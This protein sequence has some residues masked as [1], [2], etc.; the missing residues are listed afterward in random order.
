MKNDNFQIY[1]CNGEPIGRPEGYKNHSTALAIV[2]RYNGK[3]R[4]KIWT[5]YQARDWGDNTKR[6]LYTITVNNTK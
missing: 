5:A 4:A 3:I 1:D 2:H 6:L